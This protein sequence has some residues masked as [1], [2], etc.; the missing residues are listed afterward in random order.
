MSWDGNKQTP[1][2]SLWPLLGLLL[3]AL[4]LGHDVIMVTVAAAEPRPASGTIHHGSMPHAIVCDTLA[5]ETHGSRSGHPG[6]C[7]VGQ[8][9]LP[10][11]ARELDHSDLALTVVDLHLA[12]HAPTGRNTGSSAWKE[13]HWPPGTLRALFQ[14]YR[15]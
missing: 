2:G 12:S 5:S 4:F 3:V 14:V 6:N 10:R 13:P 7:G 15:L 9:A 1:S 8:F 11:S